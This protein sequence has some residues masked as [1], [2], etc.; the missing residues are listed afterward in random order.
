MRCTRVWSYLTNAWQKVM[1]NIFAEFF[2]FLWEKRFLLPKIT[3]N[4]FFNLRLL[5]EFFFKSQQISIFCLQ[6][7]KEIFPKKST[8]FDFLAST[9]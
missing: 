5:K 1:V 6:H 9:S 3:E 7:T 8:N 4:H 2:L